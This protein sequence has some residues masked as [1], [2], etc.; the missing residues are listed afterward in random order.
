MCV[1]PRASL[2]GLLFLGTA[3]LRADDAKP[4][5]DADSARWQLA[6]E[7]Q[8]QTDGAPDPAKWTIETGVHF[9]NE[10]QN[11]VADP[12]NVR[13]EGGNLVITCL[14]DS[15]D[16][17][18]PY[19]SARL[20]T[21]GKAQW[22]YGRFEAEIKLPKGR[23]SWPAFWMLGDPANYGNWPHCGE[24]D[25]MENVG[26]DPTKI[27]GTIH[28]GAFNWPKHS[29]KGNHTEVPD[30]TDA[31]HVYAVEWLPK[32][33][34]FFVDGTK[35][36]TFPNT[37]TGDSEQ[38]PFDKP[39]FLLLNYAIGGD[40]GGVKGIDDSVLPQSMLV[41]YVRVYKP[42]DAAMAEVLDPNDPTVDSS[43]SQFGVKTDGK[44]KPPA[45]APAP[46]P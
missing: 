27:H 6:W 35:F 44:P 9:N 45:P 1:S 31:F 33:I 40:W 20:I 25:I 24:I 32:G 38:W 3:L 41:H 28:T 7:D 11:Y 8:F 18:H 26:Y 5:V 16:K 30:N 21:K 46:T 39:A 36:F 15:G 37:N 43:V 34:S 17:G 19:T 10:K 29:Q 13:V 22:T 14:K 42:T 4:P 2:L 12:K 23:G